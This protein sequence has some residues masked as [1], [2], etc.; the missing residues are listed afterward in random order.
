MRI[1]KLK[2]LLNTGEAK[3]PEI[4]GVEQKRDRESRFVSQHIKLNLSI[5]LIT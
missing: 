2:R 3:A 1:D 4:E 5:K